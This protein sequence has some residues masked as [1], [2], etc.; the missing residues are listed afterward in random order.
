MAEAGAVL[1][2]EAA[3]GG[4]EELLDA[5][6]RL[7]ALPL[8]RATPVLYYNRDAFRIAHA[9]PGEAAGHLVRHGADA[10]RAGRVG[11]RLR[12]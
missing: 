1:R 9:R 12:A 6:G 5:E 10:R 11:Q 7:L 2:A 3:L 8:G 4:A